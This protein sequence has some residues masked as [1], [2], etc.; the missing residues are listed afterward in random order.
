MRESELR[1]AVVCKHKHSAVRPNSPYSQTFQNEAATAN[2]C[3]PYVCMPLWPC[4][5]RTN[6]FNIV[7]KMPAFRWSCVLKYGGFVNNGNGASHNL[8]SRLS[9]I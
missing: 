6:I 4:C 8:L 5:G 3:A 7:T 1:D 9:V 2:V